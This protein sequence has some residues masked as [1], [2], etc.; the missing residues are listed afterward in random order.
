MWRSEVKA[1]TLSY[2]LINADCLPRYLLQPTANIIRSNQ[3]IL[4]F[5][6]GAIQLREKLLNKFEMAYNYDL[7]KTAKKYY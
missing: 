3:L 4:N 5:L 6:F 1:N 7:S 2:G